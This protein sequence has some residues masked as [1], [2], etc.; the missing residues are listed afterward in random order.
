M[1][2]ITF[3]HFFLIAS[4]LAAAPALA[5]VGATSS[6]VT[7]AIGTQ[8]TNAS[9]E[10]QQQSAGFVQQNQQL[11]EGQNAVSPSGV[12]QM[13]VDGATIMLSL[14]GHLDIERERVRIQKEIERCE[15]EATKSEKKLANADFV[16]KAPAEV[17]GGLRERLAEEISKRDKL[18]VAVERLK[19][20]N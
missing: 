6:G 8:G 15:A 10:V 3:R 5:G 20:L 9:P 18:L 17:V 1:H 19:N 13:V 11:Q 12:V 4:W 14:T 7:S 16:A 2:A